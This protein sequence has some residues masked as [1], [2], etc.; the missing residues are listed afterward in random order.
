MGINPGACDLHA[1]AS[2]HCSRQNLPGHALGHIRAPANYHAALQL[3]T[4]T[5]VPRDDTDLIFEV[6]RANHHTTLTPSA[7]KAKLS[8][9]PI[10][11]QTV[12][13]QR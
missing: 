11:Y 2:D 1:Y 9:S 13:P 8:V 5:D 12:R 10:R 3:H 7:L 6:V 4:E